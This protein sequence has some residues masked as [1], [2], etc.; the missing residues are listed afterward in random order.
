MNYE[1]LKQRAAVE[2]Q[3]DAYN[4]VHEHDDLI[5]GASMDEID[6][7]VEKV[8]KALRELRIAK[9]DAERRKLVQIKPTIAE[10]SGLVHDFTNG[11][12]TKEYMEELSNE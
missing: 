2:S 6:R 12:S 7:A 3:T 11:K 1:E 4:F 9:L 5:L 10:M 8:A